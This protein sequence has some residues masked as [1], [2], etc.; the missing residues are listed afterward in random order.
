MNPASSILLKCSYTVVEGVVIDTLLSF[1]G[2]D[3]VAADTLLQTDTSNPTF[4]QVLATLAT[5]LDYSG[6]AMESLGMRL[7]STL[8]SVRDCPPV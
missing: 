5:A 1:T 7:L 3:C 6:L 8:R 4:T 2:N